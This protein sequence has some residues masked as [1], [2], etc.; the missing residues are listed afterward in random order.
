MDLSTIKWAYQRCTW[1]LQLY[2]DVSWWA[3][4]NATNQG[5][6]IWQTDID[7]YCSLMTNYETDWKGLE[8]C[9]L[10]LHLFRAEAKVT[11]AMC[12]TTKHWFA[13]Y[14]FPMTRSCAALCRASSQMHFRRTWLVPTICLEK[15]CH[16]NGSQHKSRKWKE[17]RHVLNSCLHCH[18]NSQCPTFNLQGTSTDLVDSL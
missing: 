1:W 18:C 15:G 7:W 17:F 4:M 8:V 2:R 3:E 13:S 14:S 12:R 6:R 16:G 5:I 9:F 10:Q 11:L